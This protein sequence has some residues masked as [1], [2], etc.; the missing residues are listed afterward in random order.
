MEAKHG[1]HCNTQKVEF[2]P[3][4]LA[5]PEGSWDATLLWCL[6]LI[7][8]MGPLTANHRVI[9]YVTQTV[10][11]RSCWHLVKCHQI[12][13]IFNSGSKSKLLGLNSCVSLLIP[14]ISRANKIKT[15]QKRWKKKKG[16]WSDESF[17]TLFQ[18]QQHYVTT[19][20]VQLTT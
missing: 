9:E 16:T 14:V 13:S 1:A 12:K 10:A 8:I 7:A 17:F 18:S 15:R 20:R 5:E 3:H 4:D 19:Q 6:I 11:V 2:R